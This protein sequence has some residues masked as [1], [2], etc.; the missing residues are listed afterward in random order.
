MTTPAGPTASLRAFFGDKLAGR[1]NDLATF[2]EVVV[3]AH[4][5]Q[6]G[7]NTKV[8]LT[9][10]NAVSYSAALP[11][12]AAAQDGC[13]PLSAF[14]PDA[15]LPVPRPYPGLLPLQ[16]QPTAPPPLKLAD[17]EVLQVTWEAGATSIPSTLDIESVSLR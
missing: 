2:G 4:T 12:G 3:R 11:L 10:K 8:T 13:I 7:T 15:L 14:R 16:Y 9:T 17:A 6:S 1:L 5:S